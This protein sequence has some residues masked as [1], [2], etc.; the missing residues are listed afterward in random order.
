MMAS[1]TNSRNISAT[2]RNR[3]AEGIA[4]LQAFG[5]EAHSLALPQQ[6]R[7]AA[8]PN[9]AAVIEGAYYPLALTRH[10]IADALAL[11][12]QAVWRWTQH[13][14]FPA[15]VSPELAEVP[16]YGCG[17]K[18]R[19]WDMEEVGAWLKQYAPQRRRQRHAFAW[20]ALEYGHGLWEPGAGYFPNPEAR[21]E[22]RQAER[23][24]RHAWFAKQPGARA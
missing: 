14:K 13:P 1:F 20:W 7:P 8:V 4:R 2:S 17:R 9:V 15:P 21:A 23:I 12:P 18:P 16:H 3:H 24:R 11:Q 6:V 19:Y 10:Q 5:I 22:W